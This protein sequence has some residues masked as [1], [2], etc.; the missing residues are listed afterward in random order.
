MSKNQ[1]KIIKPTE[2]PPEELEK[3]VM[4][5][6]KSIVLMV[7]VLQLFVG[8]I[9]STLVHLYK[10]KSKKKKKKGDLNKDK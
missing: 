9:E 8:D 5:S 4:G 2:D 6:V 3:E 1:F 7:R 10:T